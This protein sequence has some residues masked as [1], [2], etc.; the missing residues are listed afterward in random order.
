MEDLTLRSFA[1][2]RLPLALA[3]VAFLI[4]VVGNL[5]WKGQRAFLSHS[6][7]DGRI[8]PCRAVGHGGVRSLFVHQATRR[9]NS[10]FSPR[11]ANLRD[12]YYEFSSVW[13]YTNRDPLNLERTL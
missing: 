5:K 13:F 10:A 2:L 9:S 11:K 6:S 7:H 3:V 4:G 1:Y 12:P 8:F